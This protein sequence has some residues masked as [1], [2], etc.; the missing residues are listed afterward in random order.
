MKKKT[1]LGRPP[2]SESKN[3]RSE[4]LAVA[5][6]LFS[7]QGYEA[8][9]VRQIAERVGVSDPALYSHFTGKAEILE[10]LFEI[11]GPKAVYLTTEN[12]DLEDALRSPREFANRALTKLAERW[13]DPSENK[14][15]RLLLIENLTGNLDPSM[16]IRALQ[17]PLRKRL[18][19]LVEWLIATKRAID[20][21][22]NWMVSQFMDPIAAI[23]TEV[24]MAPDEVTVPMIQKKLLNHFENFAKVFLRNL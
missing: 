7:S 6:D 1:R 3:R 20:V 5:L 14:F 24:A 23:R 19:L 16:K 4:I 9:S 21:N 12:L 11:Y 22:S 17:E 13:F 18:T 10:D 15:F 2:K 8:T